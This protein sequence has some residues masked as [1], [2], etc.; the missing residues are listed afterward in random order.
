MEE[1]QR[2]IT[3]YYKNDKKLLQETTTRQDTQQDKKIMKDTRTRQEIQD[4]AL[5]Q[6]TTPSHRK[7][8]PKTK[9]E[10]GDYN[11]RPTHDVH[12]EDEDWSGP[13]TDDSES[14]DNE[15][16]Y[17][18]GGSENGDLYSGDDPSSKGGPATKL[19][20]VTMEELEEMEPGFTTRFDEE[21]ERTFYKKKDSVLRI[22]DGTKQKVRNS[23]KRWAHDGTRTRTH[24][25][26]SERSDPIHQDR[27][28][29]SHQAQSLV[30]QDKPLYT[31]EDN[32]EY[33]D[34]SSEYD[35]EFYDSEYSDQ[36]NNDNEVYDLDRL[37]RSRRQLNKLKARKELHDSEI[38]RQRN[39]WIKRKLHKSNQ[40][41]MV[42]IPTGS[43]STANEEPAT[44]E[45]IQWKHEIDELG[46]SWLEFVEMEEAN[47]I[48]NEL[49]IRRWV[50]HQMTID[51][52]FVIR[53]AD[54]FAWADEMAH[55]QV[56]EITNEEGEIIDGMLIYKWT[57][58][59]LRHYKLEKEMELRQQQREEQAMEIR[60]TIIETQQQQ[61]HKNKK[62]KK[63]K[64]IT[65]TNHTTEWIQEWL[66]MI[67]QLDGT[68]GHEQLSKM[69][70]QARKKKRR[71]DG[72]R[73]V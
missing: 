69:A 43:K 19:R 59:A 5:H 18:E 36:N 40:P 63:R 52:K 47:D 12:G 65:K 32:S 17:D 11:R 58:K 39:I 48:D 30:R 31:S 57:H 38:N 53:A 3:D 8:K 23:A 6:R 15:S 28:G 20:I 62:D 55:D 29:T 73:K 13:Y 56:K 44:D 25:S 37:Q 27:E 71:K 67:T 46:L 35:S 51:E 10:C 64:K 22:G 16:E 14:D 2:K 45:E 49:K 42:F 26:M 50:I 72:T 54:D 24:V 61:K 70:K 34:E 41:R 4:K 21:W 7:A 1:A 60:D 66:T 33:D 9:Q 68:G